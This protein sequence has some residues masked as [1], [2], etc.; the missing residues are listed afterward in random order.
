MLRVLWALRLSGSTFEPEGDA[1]AIDLAAWWWTYPP[2]YK[3]ERDLAKRR[4]AVRAV[5]ALLGKAGMEGRVRTVPRATH[6]E[7]D[8]VCDEYDALLGLVAGIAAV[9]RSSW[10]WLAST[11]LDDGTI[12]TIADASLRA[13]FDGTT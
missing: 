1:R 6:G 9:D 7:L 2:K 11:S 3:R 8:A 12:L 10:S 13:R 4:R 5:A